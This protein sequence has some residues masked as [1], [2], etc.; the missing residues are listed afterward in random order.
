M[1]TT[2]VRDQFIRAEINYLTVRS[3]QDLEAWAVLA[4]SLS[5][6]DLALDSTFKMAMYRAL[7]NRGDSGC[8]IVRGRWRI[9]RSSEVAAILDG[10]EG[11][12]QALGF[13]LSREG[14]GASVLFR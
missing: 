9:F 12:K 3:R 13:H 8:Y 11:W 6:Q 10:Y 1:M 2:P 5:Q 14:T 4:F 7:Q